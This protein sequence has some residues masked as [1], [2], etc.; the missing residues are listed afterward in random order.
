M[1]I[2]S[3]SESSRSSLKSVE[4]ILNSMRRLELVKATQTI[5]APWT[6]DYPYQARSPASLP[7]LRLIRPD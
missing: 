1:L 3:E 6:D 4:L 5:T 7:S 2:A